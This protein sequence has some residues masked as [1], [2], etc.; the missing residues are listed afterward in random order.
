MRDIERSE[1][2]IDLNM[3]DPQFFDKL[4]R[5]FYDIGIFTNDRSQTTR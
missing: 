2:D 5:T 3:S 4:E 1:I